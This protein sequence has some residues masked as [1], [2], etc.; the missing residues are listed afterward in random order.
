[1]CEAVAFFPQ[2]SRSDFTV[3]QMAARWVLVLVYRTMLV[4]WVWG[5]KAEEPTMRRAERMA[6][7]KRF[8]LNKS[9]LLS[10]N[11]EDAAVYH[12]MAQWH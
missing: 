11:E 3:S 4:G 10:G 9:I 8:I 5:A 6:R 2:F 12:E 1:M 7:R